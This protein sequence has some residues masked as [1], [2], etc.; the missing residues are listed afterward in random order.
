MSGTWRR[1]ALVAGEPTPYVSSLDCSSRENASGMVDALKAV[2]LVNRGVLRVGGDDA[3]AFLDNLITNSMA[4][5][6]PGKAIHA[7]LLTPQGKLITDFF[8]TEADPEDGGGF[9]LDVPLVCAADL[10][11]RLTFYKL[12]A[13]VTVEDMSSALSV[14]ALWG[15]HLDASELGLGFVDPR[16]PAMGCRMIVHQTQ[17]EA[18]MMDL[19]AQQLTGEAYHALRAA[20]GLGEVAFDFIQGDVFP[21]E[22]NMD[23]LHGV[24]FK[25]G[26]F[27]GQEVVS[28]MQHRGTAR[29]RLVQL[30]FEGG[31]NIMEGAAVMA[32]DK[33]LGQTGTA[34]G[35]IGIALIRLDRAA[36]AISAGIP[37]TAGGLPCDVMKPDWWTA[38]WPITSSG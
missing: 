37:I 4:R 1:L 2:G 34:A 6:S 18:A 21:H 14:M 16:L 23:Q 35:G 26:C 32:G 17:V 15:Q 30:R 24:D 8:L 20:N 5:V 29:D 25:K 36:E 33:H 22:I 31:F 12:R 27:I 7:A 13:K 3:R 11:K 9:F 10:A 38:S 28:R 19:G